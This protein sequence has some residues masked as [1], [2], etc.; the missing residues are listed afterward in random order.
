MR[1]YIIKHYKDRL[2]E[3]KSV[4]FDRKSKSDKVGDFEFCQR[5]GSECVRVVALNVDDAKEI[6]KRAIIARNL[7]EDYADK[8]FDDKQ[9][10]ER[11]HWFFTERKKQNW[12]FTER[13]KQ[14]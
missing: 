1:A 13:K 7:R 14:K 8:H 10:N 11:N 9:Y 6:A 5:F 3:L 2:G 12:F 4:G